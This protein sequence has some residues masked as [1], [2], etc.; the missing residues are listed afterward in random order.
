MSGG[1]LIVKNATS[2]SA[3]ELVGQAAVSTPAPTWKLVLKF[4]GRDRPQL[5]YAEFHCEGSVKPGYWK[6]KADDGDH[7]F[8]WREVAWA[9]SLFY[10]DYVSAGLQGAAERFQFPGSRTASLAQ[11]LG[12]AICKGEGK[13]FKLFVQFTKDKGEFSRVQYVFDGLNLDG[14]KEGERI[15]LPKRDKLPFQAVEIF[16]DSKRLTKLAD[17]QKLAGQIRKAEKLP[18]ATALTAEEKPEVKT[19]SQPP[20]DPG[21]KA[22][23]KPGPEKKAGPEQPSSPGTGAKPPPLPPPPVSERFPDIDVHRDYILC[24]LEQGMTAAQVW[25]MLKIRANAEFEEQRIAEYLEALVQELFP[26][27]KIK[28]SFFEVPNPDRDW[29]EDVPLMRNVLENGDTNW[30]WTVKDAC[31]GTL[32]L[33]SPG[34]GKTSGSGLSLAARFLDEGFGGLVLTAKQK[35]VKDWMELAARA[36]RTDDLAVI[37]ADGFLRLNMLQYEMHR[38]SPGGVQFSENLVSFFKNL[39]S[40][41]GNGCTPKVNESFWEDAGNELIRRTVECFM[42]ADFPVT[43]DNL[44]SFI[45]QAPEKS[46]SAKPEVW[47]QRPVFGACM[48]QAEAMAKS[49]DDKGQYSVLCEY[50]LYTYPNLNPNTRSC[51][52]TAFSSMVGAL[53]SRYINKLLSA[54]TTLT[55]ESIFNGRIIIVNLPINDFHEAGLLVQAAWKYLFQRAVLSR[56]DRARGTKC[57]PVF[58]WEDEAQ[59]FMIDFDAKFQPV[60]R[61]YRVASVKISQNISNFYARFGGGDSARTKVDAI[62]GSLN[63]KIFHANGDMVTNEWASRLIGSEM[64]PNVSTSTTPAPAYTGMNPVEGLIHWVNSKPTVTTNQG[65]IREPC[66]HPHEFTGLQV[67]SK[68]NG[69]ETFAVVTQ[70]GRIFPES[71]KSYT[72][73][74]FQQYELKPSQEQQ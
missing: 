38:P 14:K 72:G 32:I 60:A 33:G 49:E 66:V 19:T 29:P 67:G 74:T 42:L 39:A 63:T 43:L 45:V 25:I 73:M 55:P 53:R 7:S 62:L 13:I 15:I 71:Q 56:P 12:D 48:K 61:E 23:A 68:E 46:A 28:P 24:C 4:I 26:I 1:I 5:D 11:S 22:D 70:V 47:E 9:V 34:S 64:K 54:N 3:T 50:W 35:D 58:L 30:A 18:A 41:I 69:Y 44:C 52:T 37:S 2:I 57:R 10:L 8:T 40:A 51:I 36:G 27:G 65:V 31:Q 20:G 21:K 59:N 16:W 6:Q 17:I